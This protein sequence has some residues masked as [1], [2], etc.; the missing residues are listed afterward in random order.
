MTWPSVFFCCFL[1]RTLSSILCL[2]W[3]Q[4]N[5]SLGPLYYPSVF[6]H[7]CLFA[8]LSHGTFFSIS[9]SCFHTLISLP[10]T[11]TSAFLPPPCLF[12]PSSS[13]L[14]GSWW[15]WHFSNSRRGIC[16]RPHPLLCKEGERERCM[17]AH[18]TGWRCVSV[19]S[20]LWF[21]RGFMVIYSQP[22]ELTSIP[23]KCK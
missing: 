3:R 5:K 16:T 21:L 7:L 10:F 8:P 14:Q 4:P 6:L 2:F 15:D 9:P 22:S 20:F 13:T 18:I 17:C 1:Q 19:I 23:R 12:L 11:P